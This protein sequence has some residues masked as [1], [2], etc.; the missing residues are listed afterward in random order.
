MKQLIR[1]ILREHVDELSEAK[2]SNYEVSDEPYANIFFI[3]INEYNK[4]KSFQKSNL[5][6]AFQYAIREYTN[7]PHKLI[8]KKVADHFIS[9]FTTP[10]AFF[11]EA[12]S[13]SKTLEEVKLAMKEYSGVCLLTREEDNCLNTKGYRQKRPQGWKLAYDSC[14]IQVMDENQYNS[15]KLEKLN[16]MEDETTD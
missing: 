12:L 15:Y 3:F 16:S 13:K 11:L 1:H 2:F 5:K 4:S 9:N 6:R 7:K 8:S 14:D 10:V